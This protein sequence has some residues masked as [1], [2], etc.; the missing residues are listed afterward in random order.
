MI[1]SLVI[2]QSFLV[3]DAALVVLALATG[4]MVVAK[5]L[6]A[7]LSIPPVQ[8]NEADAGAEQ[9]Y[10]RAVAARD[11]YN[12]PLAARLF[13]D[14]GAYDPGA[15]PVEAPLETAQTTVVET[16]LNLRLIGTTATDTL[17]SAIIE[18]GSMPGSAKSYDV[19]TVVV[20]NVTLEE[21]HPR[22]VL[23]RNKQNGKDQTEKLSMDDQKDQQVASAA[24][25][26]P[27]AGGGTER[28]TINRQELMQDLML[29]YQDLITKVKP[30][31]YRDASG[32]VVGIT[33]SNI[34]QI[35]VAQ[36]LGIQDGDVLQ[37]VNNE[38]IDS[39]A[40]VMEMIQKYQNA[41]SFRIGLLRNGKPSVV[42]YRLE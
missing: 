40:K 22:H 34:G 37:T 21:V 15:S 11:Q 23:I 32:K 33:A 9:Q 28:K 10:V 2:R 31:L 8:A 17:A 5:F 4:V 19:G 16:E 1:R 30:E 18:D 42:T 20:E 41:S 6:E 3:I 24:P 39:E 13:G 36:K 38:N 27:N 29:N 14:A 26:L 12:S 35:G 25:I 7:P